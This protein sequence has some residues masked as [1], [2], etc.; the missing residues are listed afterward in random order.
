MRVVITD[1]CTC[2]WFKIYSYNE[3][4]YFPLTSHQLVTI[5]FESFHYRAAQIYYFFA[6]HAFVRTTIFTHNSQSIPSNLHTQSIALVN[7][8]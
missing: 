3:A 6:M 2:H 1:I 8:W 5:G 4:Y 7:T